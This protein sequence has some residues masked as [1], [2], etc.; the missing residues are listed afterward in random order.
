[1]I[2]GRPSTVTA[3]LLA[4]TRVVGIWGKDVHTP[5]L[6]LHAVN[7]SRHLTLAL[8]SLD[9]ES[10][11]ILETFVRT[12]EG[13]DKQQILNSVAGM[14]KSAGNAIQQAIQLCVLLP[15]A[16][17]DA[18]ET[19]F[20]SLGQNLDAAMAYWSGAGMQ[21]VPGREALRAEYQ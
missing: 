14:C 13:E 21:A 8:Q 10:T 2:D 1:M 4:A 7:V 3:H 9:D 5:H 17:R 20:G 19:H 18:L 16:D 15:A 6:A 12:M 11:D